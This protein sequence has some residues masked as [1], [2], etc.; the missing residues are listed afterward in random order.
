MHGTLD[1]AQN[2]KRRSVMLARIGLAQ[3]S[4][5]LPIAAILRGAATIA[6]QYENFAVRK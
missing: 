5:R 1:D 3:P 6:W 2:A 4:R